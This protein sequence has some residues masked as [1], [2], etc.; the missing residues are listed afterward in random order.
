[1]VSFTNQFPD[2]EC[3]YEENGIWKKPVSP[4]ELAVYKEITPSPRILRFQGVEDDQ[5]LLLD[6]HANGNLWD[7]LLSTTP[8]LHTRIGWALEIAE[9]IAHLYSKSVIWADGHFGNVLVTEDLHVVLADFAFSLINPEDFHWFTTQ[10]P[11]IFCCPVG[12]H[13]PFPTRVDIF[14]FGVMLFGLLANRFPW[15]ANL[16]VDYSEHVKAAQR[17]SEHTFDTFEDEDLNKHFGHIVPRCLNVEYK[18]GTDVLEAMKDACENW[19][20]DRSTE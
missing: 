2:L 13:G 7:Y 18:T 9:G 6:Y 10:P 3:G 17:L 14:S 8:P 12:H 16:E 20:R 5:L 11:L 4:N 19:R 1:M 15:T